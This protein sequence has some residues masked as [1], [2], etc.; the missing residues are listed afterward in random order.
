MEQILVYI[1]TADRAEAEKIA[2]ALVE[3]R[4][5]ACANILDGV[6]S[7]FHWQGKIENSREALCLLK[8][9][10]SNFAALNSRVLEL[11]SYETP[12]VVALPL[13]DGNPSFLNWITASCR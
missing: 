9:T 5:A 1:T 12:C 8:T 10:K 3:E 13:S 6:Q 2:S 11:H 4:L 7:I